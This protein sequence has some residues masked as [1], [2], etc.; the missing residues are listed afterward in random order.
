MSFFLLSLLIAAGVPAQSTQAPA[1]ELLVDRSF[2]LAL[3]E[4][5]KSPR[6]RVETIGRSHLGRPI[7]LIIVALPEVIAD[8]SWFSPSHT[9]KPVE[10]GAG[11]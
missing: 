8:R 7:Q 11:C 3:V 9:G 4:L 1:A 5:E 10:I 2:E 6:V